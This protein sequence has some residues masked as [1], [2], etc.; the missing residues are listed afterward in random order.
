MYIP[1]RGAVRDEVHRQRVS[2][3]PALP[4]PSERGRMISIDTALLSPQTRAKLLAATAGHAPPPAHPHPAQQIQPVQQGNYPSRYAAMAARELEQRRYTTA[5]LGPTRYPDRRPSNNQRAYAPYP[6]QAYGNPPGSA[7]F[8]RRTTLP[9]HSPGYD[10]RRGSTTGAGSQYASAAYLDWKAEKDAAIAAARE[11]YI[12][13]L[14]RE[15]AEHDAA[16]RKNQAERVKQEIQ[17]ERED[18]VEAKR[19]QRKIQFQVFVHAR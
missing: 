17:K 3:A 8:H 1:S 2:N 9:A 10:A 6:Q 13:D 16:E 11:V 5:G 14:E 12:A 4:P 18:P 7:G 15:K 19:R